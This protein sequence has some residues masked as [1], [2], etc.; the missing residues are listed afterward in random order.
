MGEGSAL[1]RAADLASAGQ[2]D[3]ARELV[4]GWTQARPDDLDGWVLR[5]LL[6]PF[7]GVGGP[8]GAAEALPHETATLGG[9]L[10]RLAPGLGIGHV[11]LFQGLTAMGEL[12]RAHDA[13]DR[14]QLLVPEIVLPETTASAGVATAVPRVPSAPAE[15]SLGVLRS[16]VLGAMGEDDHRVVTWRSRAWTQLAPHDPLAW[17]SLA[18]GHVARGRTEVALDAARHLVRVAPEDP[19]AHA[20]LDEITQGGHLRRPAAL[21]AGITPLPPVPATVRDADPDRDDEILGLSSGGRREK[22]W[23]RLE[24]ELVAAP[25]DPG[26]WCL[27][28]LLHQIEG[29]AEA[30]FAS[31]DTALL[32]APWY[33]DAWWARARLEVDGYVRPPEEGLAARRGLV[34]AAPHVREAYDDLAAAL[35]VRG[36]VAGAF[37][38]AEAGL[39]MAPTALVAS[40][41]PDRDAGVPLV[42][43]LWLRTAVVQSRTEDGRPGLLPPLL[44]WSQLQPR[45]PVPF[46]AIAEACQVA[47]RTEEMGRAMI[48]ARERGAKLGRPGPDPVAS[49]ASWATLG[50]L[51]GYALV[52]RGGLGVDPPGP[53]STLVAVLVGALVLLGL[54]LGLPA[55]RSLRRLATWQRPVVGGALLATV[56]VGWLAVTDA[57]AAVAYPL[58][59]V[60]TAACAGFSLWWVLRGRRTA[61]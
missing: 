18:L 60:A 30:C 39:R 20:L 10:V 31:T 49:L 27:R 6:G 53:P 38:V 8:G 33:A 54:L 11:L 46:L 44:V 48:L 15:V 50:A 41:V 28:A 4:R 51:G 42:A 23:S 9:N 3:E 45:E 14:A 5:A 61:T 26:L 57:G 13:L 58:L 29:D 37:E 21:P 34:A 17:R 55:L 56:L 43:P 32:H 25:E 1:E 36:D 7:S 40:G 35:L 16:T 24:A 12:G 52:R 47:E 59:A 22:T 19:A 2:Y